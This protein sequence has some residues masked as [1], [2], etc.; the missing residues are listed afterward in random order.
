MCVLGC[1]FPS[2]PVRQHDRLAACVLSTFSAPVQT[3]FFRSAPNATSG[4]AVTSSYDVTESRDVGEEDAGKAG[5]GRP[6]A[7]VG[8]LTFVAG[9]SS[10]LAC[11]AVGGY[12][13]PQVRVHLG[14]VSCQ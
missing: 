8:Q 10:Y 11:V 12:P 4:H 5:S 3:V 7:A 2:H 14:Q 6:A 1:C 9:I 13:P